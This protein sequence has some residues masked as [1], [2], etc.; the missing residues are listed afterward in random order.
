LIGANA[1][2]VNAHDSTFEPDTP[3]SEIVKV[4]LN[5][6]SLDFLG[7]SVILFAV[8]RDKMAASFLDLLIS[9]DGTSHHVSG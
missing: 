5:R 9:K 7:D 4:V 3:P 1:T 2:A 6:P 8:M